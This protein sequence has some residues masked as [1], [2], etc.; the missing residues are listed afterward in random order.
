M[1][2]KLSA[3]GNNGALGALQM[4]STYSIKSAHSSTDSP[5]Y[6]KLPSSKYFLAPTVYFLPLEKYLLVLANYFLSL[7]FYFLGMEKYFLALA[8]SKLPSEKVFLALENI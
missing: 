3:A 8:I 1:F 4:A 6:C 7:A 2:S 5:K